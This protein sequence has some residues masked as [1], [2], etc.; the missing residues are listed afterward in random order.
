MRCPI[1]S[2][3]NEE[4]AV[5]CLACG[6]LFV[7]KEAEEA[8]WVLGAASMEDTSGMDG[9]GN[10]KGTSGQKDEDA[11]VPAVAAGNETIQEKIN[12]EEGTAVSVITVTVPSVEQ[13][14]A[15]TGYKLQAEELFG[16]L[17]KEKQKEPTEEKKGRVVRAV[18]A[19][20]TARETGLLIA[21]TILAIALLVLLGYFLLSGKLAE[22]LHNFTGGQESTTAATEEETQAEPETSS[23]AS[24]TEEPESTEESAT[25]TA[26]ESTVETEEETTETSTEEIPLGVELEDGIILYNNSVLLQET[27][28]G[29]IVKSYMGDTV[30]V[31]PGEYDG[32]PV[33]AI[34]DN[35]F[36]G[37]SHV[38]Q[39]E[40]QEGIT[41][42]GNSAFYGCSSLQVLALPDSLTSIGANAFD[43]T[44]RFTVISHGNTYA[45]QYCVT[46]GI[47]WADGTGL[48]PDGSVPENA[49]VPQAGV[50]AET[51]PETAPV[52]ETPATDAAGAV[53]S[54]AESASLENTP[55]NEGSETQE[56]VVLP[57]EDQAALEG[58]VQP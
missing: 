34:A 53:S 27:E 31:I 5:E 26:E 7:T 15:D 28:A 42:I 38:T 1:C 3:E 45:Y 24:E 44:G 4:N 14:T 33:T 8:S 21:V 25:E 37:C 18:K 32:K 49:Q 39:V 35:A 13:T 22:S 52:Q 23:S 56:T 12:E 48:L 9:Y 50:P 36:S 57:A 17:S 10:T 51:Q 40:V 16:N 43:Y 47:P 41:S 29:Y 58:E 19:P 54:E 11:E 6:Y 46:L 20:I 55:A 2:T 30:A